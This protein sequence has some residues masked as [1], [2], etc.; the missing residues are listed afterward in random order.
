LSW[1]TIAEVLRVEVANHLGSIA[2]DLS[3]LVPALKERL[4]GLLGM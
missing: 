1:V 2:G 4:N 3:D